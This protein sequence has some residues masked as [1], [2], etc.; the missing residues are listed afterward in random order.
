MKELRKEKG[1]TQK[2]AAAILGVGQTSV[3]NYE[4]GTRFP[5]ADKLV[6]MADLFGVSVDFL[7]GREEYRMKEIKDQTAAD[8]SEEIY[9]FDDYMHSLLTKNKVMVRKIILA[10]ISRGV[11]SDVIYH[12]FLE[13]AMKETG[14]LWEKG[15]LPVWKEHFISEMT[16]ENLALI[17]SRRILERDT[18][19]PVLTLAPGA[20]A[21]TIG[22]RMISDM[23]E[24][25]GCS[26]I[27][28]GNNVPSDNVLLAIKENRPSAVLLS[29]TMTQHVDTVKMLV[30][31]IKQRFGTRAPAILVGGS[32]F[33][34]MRNVETETGADKY[35][36][37][38][39]EI[40][41]TLKRI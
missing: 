18:Q 14:T 28:L 10:L 35:C 7:L 17:K 8:E 41:K 22:I 23:L 4:N 20:E 38:Y 11:S 13:R 15:E 29:V 25:D 1:L 33:V 32:A 12:E 6:A 9:G 21:H 24:A 34:G 5:D 40:Q 19:R 2:D 36:R 31:K 30:E 26:V 39:E 37:T 3:A 27:Y 16:L